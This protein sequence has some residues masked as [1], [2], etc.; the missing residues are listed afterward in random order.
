MMQF[1]GEA[2]FLQDLARQPYGAKIA[3]IAIDLEKYDRT[4]AAHIKEVGIRTYTV[5]GKHNK[6]LHYRIKEHTFRTNRYSPNRG[7]AFVGKSVF[8]KIQEVK[9]AIH[10]LVT[11][12]QHKY[13]TVVVIG[14]AIANDLKWLN[15]SGMW[16]PPTG[17][18]VLDTQAIQ[19]AL[20][21]DGARDGMFEFQMR[22]LTICLDIYGKSYPSEQQH[23]AGNDAAQTIELLLAQVRCIR[24]REPGAFRSLSLPP[25]QPDNDYW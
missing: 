9:T 16:I 2:H 10:D 19:L 5:D 13:D 6:T 4:N 3:F 15:D 14:H 22:S 7:D 17:I 24:Q 25:Y 18:Q 1:Y 23:N 12:I 21:Y 8:L 20:Q 11:E